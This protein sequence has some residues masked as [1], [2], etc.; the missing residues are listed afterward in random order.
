MERL[1]L[2]LFW[3]IWLQCNT[4]ASPSKVGRLIIRANEHIEETINFMTDCNCDLDG[5]M[6]FSVRDSSLK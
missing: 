1:S 6:K 4:V 2:F 3:F 5:E